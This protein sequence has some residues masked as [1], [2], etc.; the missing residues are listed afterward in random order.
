M[1]YF[2]RERFWRVMAPAPPWIMKRG[3][4][5]VGIVVGNEWG[6]GSAI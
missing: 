6:R 4:V 1:R 2:S 5:V 3:L